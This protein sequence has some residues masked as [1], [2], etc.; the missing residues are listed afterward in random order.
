MNKEQ[1]IRNL[2]EWIKNKVT[3]AG[4]RGVVLGLSG[5]VD[6]SVLAALC[7]RAFPINTIGVI[8]PCYSAN[9]DKEYAES[10]ARQFEV[11]TKT[12]VL[13][14]A[15]DALI[16]VLPTFKGDPTAARVAQAN[17]KA[18]LRMVT[19]Y[20]IANQMGYLVA[21]SGNRS[22]IT[23]GYFTKHGDAGADILPLGNLVKKEVKV[24]ARFLSIPRAIIDKLPSAGLWSGQSDEAEMGFSYEALDRY[25]LTGIATNDV[26]SRIE[27]MKASCQHKIQMPPIPTF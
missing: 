16:A 22:E 15:Y 21:G 20:Y 27:F 7:K 10:I 9:E 1:R 24:L 11:P 18:R 19:L 4:S 6:S 3:A 17:I 5:G 26:K 2:V 23:I 14:A 12:V 8:M 13:N 25:I